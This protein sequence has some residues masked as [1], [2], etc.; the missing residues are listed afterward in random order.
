MALNAST[1]KS[2]SKTSSFVK[3]EPLEEAAYPARL[4]Q[5]I[6]LGMHPVGKWNEATRKFDLDETKAPVQNIYLTY[7]LVTE[8]LKDKD[9][10]EMEDKPRWASEQIPLYALKN[11]KATSSKRINAIDP[12]GVHNG[13]LVGMLGSGCTLVLKVTD[14]GYNKI[15][16][17]TP[18]MKGMV[19][20]ELKNPPLSL[21]LDAP[22][23]DVYNGLPDFLKDKILSS[24]GFERTALG[25][26]LDVPSAKEE[27]PEEPDVTDGEYD[28]ELPW[29]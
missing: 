26:L 17:V 9:G 1:I 28:E 29:G 18:L 12:K 3:Q 2:N 25:K 20:P 16:S 5:V 14:K 27:V 10:V 11:D 19:I 8:F 22:N 24:V 15:G 7:E 21:D 13:D 6:D 23:L 4:V